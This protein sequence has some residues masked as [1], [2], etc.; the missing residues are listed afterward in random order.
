MAR[1]RRRGRNADGRA[2]DA[3]GLPV[4]GERDD[5]VVVMAMRKGKEG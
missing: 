5:A 4:S 1:R 2:M 3:A